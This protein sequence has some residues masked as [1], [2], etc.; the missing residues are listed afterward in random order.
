MQ[1]V[2]EHHHPKPSAIVQRYHF[3]S[4]FRQE[5]ESISTYVSELKKL[6]EHC[7]FQDSLNDMLRDR[8]VCG[9]NNARLQRRLLAEPD[10]TFG[11]AME[12]A[13]ALEAA[14]RNAKDIVKPGAAAIN[15]VYISKSA[16]EEQ[17]VLL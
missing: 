8:L 9:V 1:L 4:R 14:E 5:G 6:S 3:H 17:P 11:K 10:L 15:M 16:P 7:N 13:L 2:Q 12:L